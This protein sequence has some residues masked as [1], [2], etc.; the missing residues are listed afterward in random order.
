MS[1]LQFFKRMQFRIPPYDDDDEDSSA[2]TLLI[3]CEPEDDFTFCEKKEPEVGQ[4]DEV[5][6]TAATVKNI[7]ASKSEESKE[8]ENE[9]E[10]GDACPTEDS[11]AEEDDSEAGGRCIEGLQSWYHRNFRSS[12]LLPL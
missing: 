4:S 10:E 7:E 6:T 3:G 5:Q 8:G 9:K 1:N 11:E 2:Y 12:L